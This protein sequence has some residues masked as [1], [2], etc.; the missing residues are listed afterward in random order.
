MCRMS[1]S[2]AFNPRILCLQHLYFL[3]SA[4]QL[5]LILPEIQMVYLPS[6]SSVVKV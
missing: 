1:H 4:L 6:G 3:L 5:G 2:S